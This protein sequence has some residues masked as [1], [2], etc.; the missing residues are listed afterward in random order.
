MMERERNPISQFENGFF[1][2][3]RNNKK[4]KTFMASKVLKRMSTAALFSILIVSLALAQSIPQ[5]KNP[6]EVGFSKERLQKISAWLQSDVDKK[7]IP[8]AVVLILRKGKIAYY[9]A[10]GYQDREKNIPMARNSIFRI[11]SMTKPIVALAIMMLVEDG[12]LQLSDPV[13]Q[14]LPEFKDLKVGVEKTDLSTGKTELVLET[15]IRAMT[16]QDLLRHTSGITY[17]IFGKKS[18]VKDKYNAANLWDRN[19]T[20]AELITKLSQLPLM[21]HPGTVWDYSMSYEV[22]GRIVEVV[23]GVELKT[24]VEERITKPLKLKDTAFWVEGSE[25]QARMAEPQVDPKT[26]KRSPW[27]PDLTQQAKFAS[28]GGGMASTADDYARLCLLFYNG[29]TLDGSR[30]VSRKTFE[31]M[32]SNQIPPGYKYST[33][34]FMQISWRSASSDTGQGYGLGFG[35]N[36]EPALNP[37]L[38]S[39]GDYYWTGLYGTIFWIDPKEQV[40]AIMMAQAMGQQHPNQH[41]LR[42]FVYE[43]ILN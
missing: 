13:Y 37:S 9:E 39:K 26:G 19:Q 36:S 2:L 14:Y 18:I 11:A 30:L 10:F 12:K 24:F 15:P 41:R 27:Y 16:V 23:S 35:V 3:N 32:T 7:I 42:N 21:Y 4:E 8:G 22:L 17:G 6:E 43:A 38:G 33:E 1:Y 34:A 40:I 29:G 25:R 5:A 31:Q 28:G 20:N